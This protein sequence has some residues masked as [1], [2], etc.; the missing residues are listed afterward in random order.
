MQVF[1]FVVRIVMQRF[2]VCK[3]IGRSYNIPEL[4]QVPGM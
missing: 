3:Y 2:L 4:V 1:C